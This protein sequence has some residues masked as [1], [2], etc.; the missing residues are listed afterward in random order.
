MTTH[1]SINFPSYYDDHSSEIEA[2]GYFADLTVRFEGTEIR[3]T[4]YDAVRLAQ[5]CN[6]AFASNGTYFSA[7]M[8][9]IVPAVTRA[10]I[11]AAIDALAAGGFADLGA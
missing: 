6:D 3:P 5:E 4:I 10:N 2:K 7:P 1:Y 9:I 11:V 8:M